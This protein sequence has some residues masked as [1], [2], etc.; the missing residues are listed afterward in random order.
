MM[1]E[2]KK[3]IVFIINP[4]SGLGKQKKAEAAIK[5]YLD[6]SAYTYEIAYTSYAHHAVEISKKTS[7]DGVDIVVAIGGDGSANDVAQGLINSETI[8]GLIPVGSGNGLA[9]HLKIPMSFKKSIG[10]INKLKISRI[11]TATINDKLFISI[12]GLGFDALV[13]EEFAHCGKRGFWA[14]LK[15]TYKQFKTY[16]PAFYK[17]RFDEREINCSALLV[18]FANSNQFGYNVC[19]APAAQVDNGFL[20]LC[21]IHPVS[22][23]GAAFM[24]HRFFMKNIDRSKH[25]EIYKVK[26]TNVEVSADVSCHIDGDPVEHTNS[27]TVKIKPKSLNI[28]IP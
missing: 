1:R 7:I 8:L 4:V 15:T 27:A 10:I 21:I 3:K 23:F 13:A 19:I 17:I 25:V 9:H 16:K 28:I 12:A 20:E 5:K 6:H 18:S 22:I 24:A 26:D 2:Q 11:D 14:Y